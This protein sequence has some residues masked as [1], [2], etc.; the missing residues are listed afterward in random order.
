VSRN[1][2]P[3]ENYNDD[4]PVKTSSDRT[5]GCT[6]GTIAMVI[7]AVKALI[8]EAAT[9]LALLIFVAGVMLLFF[10]LLAPARLS[11]LNWYW[12]Q[13][14]AVIAKVVNPIILALLFILVVTPLAFS[15]RLTGKRPLRLAADPAAASYWIARAPGE[16]RTSSMRRQF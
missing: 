5:F 10:G 16:S 15:M 9:P 3:H 2:S 7:G 4:E 1:F 13:L 14:G 11:A 6:V 12:L 8:A